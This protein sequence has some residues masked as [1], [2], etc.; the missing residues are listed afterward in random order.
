MV[1]TSIINYH[2]IKIITYVAGNRVQTG[3]RTNL[4]IHP[5]WDF[6]RVFGF[7]LKYFLT[8]L[9]S[10]YPQFD[11]YQLAISVMTF[12]I[13]RKKFHDVALFFKIVEKS[14]SFKILENQQYFCQK[15]LSNKNLFGRKFLNYYREGGGQKL[16]HQT[17]VCL[18][19]CNV[20]T[21]RFLS[22]KNRT[23]KKEFHFSIMTF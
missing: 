15:I 12:P 13:F 1:H 7:K 14:T 4:K 18:Y 21:N 20:S 9:H 17:R 10:S 16:V 8:T 6:L 5:Q 19:N 11:S 23:C 3:S 22:E 2:S